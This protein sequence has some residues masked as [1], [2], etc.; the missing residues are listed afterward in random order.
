MYNIRPASF[1]LRFHKLRFL[2]RRS[3]PAQRRHPLLLSQLILSEP[4]RWFSDNC[5]KLEIPS[6]R[7]PPSHR[8]HA[9]GV[10][11]ERCSLFGRGRGSAF[12]LGAPFRCCLECDENPIPDLHFTRAESVL[13]EFVVVRFRDVV[14]D[15]ERWNGVAGWR[16]QLSQLLP[17]LLAPPRPGCTWPLTCHF[18]ACHRCAPCR[19]DEHKLR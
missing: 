13:F 18:G 6:I 12:A 11:A 19:S 9:R 10:G 8:D 17:S 14:R 3:L 4:L 7:L 15:T 1:W 5:P 16:S 2:R